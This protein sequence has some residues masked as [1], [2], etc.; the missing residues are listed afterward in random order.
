MP[1]QVTKREYDELMEDRP[2]KFTPGEVGYRDAQRGEPCCAG[3]MHYFVGLV[4]GRN[5]CEI[6]RPPGEHV[7]PEYTCRFQTRDG[8]VF[9]LLGE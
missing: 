7:E 4:M 5:V 2:K 1:E 8:K 6:M 3:C 9:P